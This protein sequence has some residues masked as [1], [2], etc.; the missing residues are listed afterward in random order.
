MWDDT[1]N[2]TETIFKSPNCDISHATLKPSSPI[3]IL[4]HKLYY[5]TVDRY[6]TNS[7]S[8]FHCRQ[9]TNIPPTIGTPRIGR[10]LTYIYTDHVSGDISVD[11]LVEMQ[12]S[13]GQ[14]TV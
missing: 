12:S 8:I 4:K 1:N 2:R 13:A 3:L 11:L 9:L 10:V 7:Q 6:A 14:C 5:T